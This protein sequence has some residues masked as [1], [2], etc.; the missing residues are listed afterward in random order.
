MSIRIDDSKF[1]ICGRKQ[2]VESVFG[3]LK[4][5]WHEVEEAVDS[6]L[7]MNVLAIVIL[8]SCFLL[9]VLLDHVSAQGIEQHYLE[10]GPLDEAAN[11]SEWDAI[12]EA[13]AKDWNSD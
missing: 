1:S 10:L 4:L 11:V 2:L 9:S 13:Y 7:Q 3:N 8:A 12:L 5:G 6:T